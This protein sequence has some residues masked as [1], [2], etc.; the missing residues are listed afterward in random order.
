[1]DAKEIALNAFYTQDTITG[2]ET[3]GIEPP[4]II[5]GVRCLDGQAVDIEYTYPAT[6]GLSDCRYH[7]T[8]AGKIFKE[9]FLIDGGK[10]FIL[11]NGKW[12]PKVFENTLDDPDIKVMIDMFYSDLNRRVG[13]AA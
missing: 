9:S 13:G 5:K 7:D 8:R 4:R 11:R 6:C 2:T 12:D 1:M 3:G 10:L